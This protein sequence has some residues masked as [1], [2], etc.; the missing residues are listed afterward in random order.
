[1][2]Q[3]IIL[4]A[5]ACMAGAANAQTYFTR[6]GFI[7]FYSTTSQENIRAENKQVY[8]LIDPAKKTIAFTLLVKGFLFEKELMQQHFNE[9][10]AESDKY[11]KASFT[12]TFQGNVG[13]AAGDYPVQVTGQL[14]FHGVTQTV[15]IPATISVQPGK[16]NAKASFSLKPEDYKISIPSLVREKIAK[17]IKVQVQAECT[18]LNK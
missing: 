13:T 1:M 8:A 14:N 11:P 7:G 16:L 6:N 17:E 15:N 3:I 5:F 10:Y 2:K 18:P 4:L 12:G 9:N